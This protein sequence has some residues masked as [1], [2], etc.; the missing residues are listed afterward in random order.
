VQGG[1]MGR[2]DCLG[3]GVGVCVSNCCQSRT[4]LHYIQNISLKCY[5]NEVLACDMTYLGWI[6][7]CLVGGII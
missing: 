5:L 1:C 7:H 3:V 4:F 6:I 2:L